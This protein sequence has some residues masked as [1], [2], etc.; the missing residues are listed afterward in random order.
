MPTIYID[1]GRAFQLALTPDAAEKV[2]VT[3]DECPW[4]RR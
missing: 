2:V 3:F 4:P 1:A